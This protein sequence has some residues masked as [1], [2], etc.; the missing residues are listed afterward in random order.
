MLN[1]FFQARDY[2]KTSQ[3]DFVIYRLDRLEKAGLLNLERLPFSIRILLESVLRQ[4]NEREFT[5]QDVINLAGWLPIKRSEPR[6][7]LPRRG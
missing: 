3:G 5:R 4:C 7:H 6:S 1:D 2:L